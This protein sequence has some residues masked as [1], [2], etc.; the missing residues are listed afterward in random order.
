MREWFDS[1]PRGD[2]KSTHRLHTAWIS[3]YAPGGLQRFAAQA[4]MERQPTAKPCVEWF[5]RKLRERSQL[6]KWKRSLVPDERYFL[7]MLQHKFT[8]RELNRLL[9]NR[10]VTD[11]DWSGDPAQTKQGFMDLCQQADRI[12]LRRRAQKLATKDMIDGGAW[13]R[14]VRQVQP[15][16]HSSDSFG[17][18]FTGE[19]EPDSLDMSSDISDEEEEE[20]KPY[21]GGIDESV[22]CRLISRS[23]WG[24]Q[25]GW[26]EP[27]NNKAWRRFERV[28]DIHRGKT[29]RRLGQRWRRKQNQNQRVPVVECSLKIMKETGRLRAALGQARVVKDS[30]IC[31]WKSTLAQGCVYRKCG[32]KKKGLVHQGQRRIGQ[33]PGWGKLSVP[34]QR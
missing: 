5:K 31:P 6:A 28:N 24:T 33:M 29:G 34:A 13:G 15:S 8:N 20:E 26:A 1:L 7:V 10:D 27:Q 21:S 3:K 32:S 23:Q 22:M 2:K 14:R 4:L 11:S 12:T 19:L 18:N 9:A 30:H 25:T 17:S 16:T